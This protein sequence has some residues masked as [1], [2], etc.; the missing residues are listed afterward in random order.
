MQRVAYASHRMTSA[1]MT[2]LRALALA[3]F[4]LHGCGS[5]GDDTRAP[6][7]GSAGVLTASNPTS[8][9]VD[10]AWTAARDRVS[11]QAS[12]EY[13]VYFSLSDDIRSATDAETNGTP[14]GDWQTGITSLT[15]PSLALRT[16]YHFNV[17]VRDEAGNIA[18]YG[19]AEG[20]TLDGAWGEVEPLEALSPGSA[21]YASLTA[22][23][24][25]DIAVRWDQQ[26]EEATQVAERAADEASFSAPFDWGESPSYTP[27]LAYGFDDVLTGAS[28]L[29]NGD[30]TLDVRFTRLTA[31]GVL[32]ETVAEDI[33]TD[34]RR[35]P[36]S[37]VARNGDAMVVWGDGSGSDMRAVR[38]RF[39]VSGTWGTPKLVSAAENLDIGNVTAACSPDGNHLIL[40]GQREGGTEH[41][42]ARVY[43]TELMDF[44]AAPAA[45]G[46]ESAQ[47]DIGAARTDDGR[48][49]VVWSEY[50]SDTA[51]ETYR[52]RTYANGAWS[53]SADALATSE[54]DALF[55]LAIAAAGNDV[56]VAWLGGSELRTRRLAAGASAF[57]EVSPLA[58]VS[59]F[60]ALVLGGDRFGDA[61]LVWADGDA[62]HARVFDLASATWGASLPVKEDSS[63][64]GS[65]SMDALIDARRRITVTWTEWNPTESAFN[66]FGRTFR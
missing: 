46:Y 21:Y 35:D 62:L 4:F 2:S 44:R 14:A 12:L 32:H 65:G 50:D 57:G 9:T 59:A 30:D 66:L 56:H 25:G 7:A 11:D 49:V 1:Q 5:S 34:Y 43:D 36:I 27:W 19:G 28:L 31:T 38:A 13:R 47:G 48:F 16:L 60:Q 37:C 15:V 61:L 23:S 22:S 63:E 6:V 54:S 3:T 39:R 26:E 18:A 53:G 33:E 24:R 52:T 55:G 40:F 45:L 41:V 8:S 17:L 20:T 29:D 10:L 42:Y 51:V 58:T 64:I